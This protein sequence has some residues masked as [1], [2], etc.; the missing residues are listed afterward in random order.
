MTNIRALTTTLSA[1]AALACSA[2]AADEAVYTGTFTDEAGHKGPIE[3]KLAAGDAG[4]WTANFSAKNEGTGPRRPFSCTTELTSKTD[5]G[6]TTLSGEVKMRRGTPYVMS[7]VLVDKKSL[8]ATF[9]KKDG[10]PGSG[11]FDLT[12]GKAE[13][14]KND[15][16]N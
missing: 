13:A 1:L 10:G 8:K 6:K 7:A 9:S 16:E 15:A 12:F 4:K 5:D 11:S 14:K 2:G 3:C